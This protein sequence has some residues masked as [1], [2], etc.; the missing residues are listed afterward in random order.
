MRNIYNDEYLV[1]FVNTANTIICEHQC[2]SLNTELTCTTYRETHTDTERKTQTE[3]KIGGD[4]KT[5][6]K[7]GFNRIIIGKEQRM[8]DCIALLVFNIRL[9]SSYETFTTIRKKKI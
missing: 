1:K 4:E 6:G 8:N 2:T 3:Q 5:I 9:F 7:K